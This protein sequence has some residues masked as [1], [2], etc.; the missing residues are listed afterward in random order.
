MTVVVRI[1]KG[2]PLPR[3]FR[4]KPMIDGDLHD[5]RPSDP[6]GVYVGLRPKGND[7]WND[8]SGFVVD[9]Q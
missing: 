1:K 7:A 9:V 3:T 5:F 8:A 2:Q 4:G 6:K